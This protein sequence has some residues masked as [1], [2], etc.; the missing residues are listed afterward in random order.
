MF[1]FLK[2]VIGIGEPAGMPATEA[3]NVTAAEIVVDLKRLEAVSPELAQRTIVYVLTGEAS[4]VLLQ[5]EQPAV[6]I[7][8]RPPRWRDFQRQ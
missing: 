3:D 6:S 2:S 5:L 7:C 8:G 1:D 4:S